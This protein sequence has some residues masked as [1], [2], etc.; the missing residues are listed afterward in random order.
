MTRFTHDHL[1]PENECH[2]AVTALN[3]G[4]RESS[5]CSETRVIVSVDHNSRPIPTDSA[6]RKNHPNPF[7]PTTTIGYDLPA[8]CHVTLTVYDILGHSI[9]TLVDEPCVPENHSVLW[10]SRTD[11]GRPVPSGIYIYQ[12]ITTPTSGSVGTYSN[13]RKTIVVR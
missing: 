1:S 8:A 7:N 5:P 6:L 13:A 11:N 3:N 9:S 12:L 2:D 10:D 4:D